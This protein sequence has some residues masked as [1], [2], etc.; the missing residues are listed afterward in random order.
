[1][2]ASEAL[3]FSKTGGLG[4]VAGALPI[5]LGHLGHSTTLVVPKYRAGNAAQQKGKSI[6]RLDVRFPA[7]TLKVEV[8]ERRLAKG[9]VVWLLDCPELYERDT[10]YGA[11]TRDYEDSPLRFATLCRAAIE[12]AIRRGARVDVVHAHDWQGGLAPLLLERRYRRDPIVGGA[13]TVFTIHNIAYQGVYPRD[14]LPALGLDAG[15][16]DPGAIEFW[17]GISLLKAGI[18]FSS[19]ITTV[20]PRYAQEIQTPELGFGFEGIVADRRGDLVGITNGIDVTVWDPSRDPH[21]PQPYDATDLKGKTAAKRH[22]L[23]AFGLAADPAAMKRPLVGMVSRLVDQKGFDLLAALADALPRLDASFV[24]LGTGEPR[25]EELWRTLA[26]AASGRIGARIGFDE[27]LAHLIEGGS[28]IF[29][30]PSRFEPCG[31]NQ[32]Y[33]LRYGT[34]PVVR[35]TGGLDDTVVEYTG[36]GGGGTGFKFTEYSPAALLEALER[37]LAMFRDKK[38]WKQIQIEGMRQDHSWD[39]SAREYV[40]VYGRAV[41]AAANRR[42]YADGF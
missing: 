41:S 33:S 20:S 8:L 39:V 2:I 6:A 32:M 17:G 29:L 19:L 35:A 10:I 34:V 14:W 7:A 5:A 11:G 4:D 18:R 26:S 22:A 42:D 40:K 3:P 30:M 31:L 24:L 23:R 27:A 37:A 36:P 13:G 16:Y 28:D 12:S 9:V 38:A 15:L 21:L 25:Y 1:M